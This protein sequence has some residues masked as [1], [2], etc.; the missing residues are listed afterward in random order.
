MSTT[1]RRES[2]AD[3]AQQE[4]AGFKEIGRCDVPPAAGRAYL[5]LMLLEHRAPRRRRPL[6][7]GAVCLT[8]GVKRVPQRRPLLQIRFGH[9]LSDRSQLRRMW[10]GRQRGMPEVP[11]EEARG[12]RHRHLRAVKALEG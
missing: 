2:H 4:A 1:T 10:N 3:D 9:R 6:S 7:E 12:A 8:P 5:R 11:E